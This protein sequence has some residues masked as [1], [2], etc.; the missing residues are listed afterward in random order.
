MFR[1]QYGIICQKTIYMMIYITYSSVKMCKSRA[2]CL[3]EIPYLCFIFFYL[4]P[5]YGWMPTG[6]LDSA[7]VFSPAASFMVLQC[8]CILQYSCLQYFA[9]RHF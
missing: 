8:V 3:L 6:S 5:N 1:R 7:R 9:Y 4:V 2:A